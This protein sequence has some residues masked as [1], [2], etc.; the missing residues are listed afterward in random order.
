MREG[1]VY[2]VKTTFLRPL[3]RL[4]VIGHEGEAKPAMK[5]AKEKRKL[6]KD[7]K[8][9][10]KPGP[11]PKPKA[12]GPVA[13][14]GP[15]V[16]RIHAAAVAAAVSAEPISIERGTLWQGTDKSITPEEAMAICG[17]AHADMTIQMLAH[18]K[19]E[20]G[21]L[22]TPDQ[23]RHIAEMAAT[24][25]RCALPTLKPANAQAYIACVA[26]GVSLD[27][28]TGRQGSQLLYAAQ[29]SSGTSRNSNAK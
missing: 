16:P 28:F 1:P 14:L 19:I 9:R 21:A 29:V 3:Y 24:A 22:P 6:R 4:P 20:P 8:P 25:Y 7:G 11:K 12:L 5:P 13:R 17:Q 27:V 18:Y 26:Q 2:A 23:A 15:A 10:Q